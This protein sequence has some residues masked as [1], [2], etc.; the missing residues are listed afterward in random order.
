MTSSKAFIKQLRLSIS[1]TPS[2]AQCFC[3]LNH[4]EQN[5][6]ICLCHMIGYVYVHKYVYIY[7][8]IYVY[9]YIDVYIYICIYIY[10]DVYIYVYIYWCIYIYLCVY[11][12]ILMYIHIFMCIYILMYIHIFMY[13]YIYWCIYIYIY[14]CIRLRFGFQFPSPDLSGESA[15]SPA[16]GAWWSPA[17]SLFPF[18]LT[19]QCK[20]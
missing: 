2:F 8:H 5:T 16:A 6:K 12:Y 4:T 3:W 18:A 10:I 14:V 11:I 9:I 19:L 13:I 15:I 7:I 1:C 17:S 20:P